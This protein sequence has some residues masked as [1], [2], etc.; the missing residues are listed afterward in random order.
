MLSIQF[1]LVPRTIQGLNLLTHERSNDKPFRLLQKTKIT[2]IFDRLTEKAYAEAE[3]WKI[4]IEM[5]RM[6]EVFPQIFGRDAAVSR[7]MVQKE[8]KLYKSLTTCEPM[9]GTLFILSSSTSIEVHS[10][11][12]NSIDNGYFIIKDSIGT[13]TNELSHEIEVS[14]AR[15]FKPEPGNDWLLNYAVDQ[16]GACF[17]RDK[18][19]DILNEDSRYKMRPGLPYLFPIAYSLEL[20]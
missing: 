19:M 6:H 3:G 18:N 10:V 7:R 13:T 14:R 4:I 11:V 8:V 16:N 20:L 1:N 2:R 17:V 9:V 5:T 12:I 15:Y